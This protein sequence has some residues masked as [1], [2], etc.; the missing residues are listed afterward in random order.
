MSWEVRKEATPAGALNYFMTIFA[1]LFLVEKPFIKPYYKSVTIMAL[2]KSLAV[3]KVCN[4]V[5]CDPKS[6]QY[7]AFN[8]N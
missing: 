6:H 8:F 1:V 5:M 4:V 3:F 2:S 7:P